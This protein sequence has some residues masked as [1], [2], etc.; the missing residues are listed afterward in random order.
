MTSTFG[1]LVDPA[2]LGVTPPERDEEGERQGVTDREGRAQRG[3]R[4]MRGFRHLVAI[5]ET[6]AFNLAPRLDASGLLRRECMAKLLP[7]HWMGKAAVHLGG[8]AEAVTEGGFASTGACSSSPAALE[9]SSMAQKAARDEPAKSRGWQAKGKFGKKDK[10]KKV[11][12]GFWKK[13]PSAADAV[14]PAGGSAEGARVVETMDEALLEQR[15]RFLWRLIDAAAFGSGSTS[16]ATRGGGTAGGA[17][18]A[19]ARLAAAQLAAAQSAAMVATGAQASL[20]G[21]K[22]GRV[23]TSSGPSSRSSVPRRSTSSVTT[24]LETTLHGGRCAALAWRSAASTPDSSQSASAAELRARTGARG[25]MLERRATAAVATEGR[26][27][28]AD[29][30][31]GPPSSLRAVPRPERTHSH[32]VRAHAA[33]A[34]APATARIGGI[35]AGEITGRDLDLAHEISA[36]RLVVTTRRR[37]RRRRRRRMS[38]TK[39]RDGGGDNNGDEGTAW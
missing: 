21:W 34:S 23:L 6:R 12:V 13:P 39:T 32:V 24:P 35:S 28:A 17:R 4:P 20:N 33:S 8:V 19:A 29:G 30:D 36:R 37:R 2:L 10:A 3:E 5:A 11:D 1:L 27:S 26:G 9:S 31:D 16:G 7:A 25:G 14:L 15:L 22:S 38:T 18:L